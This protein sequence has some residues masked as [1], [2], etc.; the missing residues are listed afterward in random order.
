MEKAWRGGCCCCCWACGG[1]MARTP[2]LS[3]L[4]ELECWTIDVDKYWDLRNDAPLITL[5]QTKQ[6]FISPRRQ[7]NFQAFAYSVQGTCVAILHLQ[8]CHPSKYQQLQPQAWYVQAALCKGRWQVLNSP[9]PTAQDSCSFC[10]QPSTH[11]QQ[12][13]TPCMMRGGRGNARTW[14]GAQPWAWGG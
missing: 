14:A 5:H 8:S 7:N 13:R 1:S 6:A 9:L 3:E 10:Q 2:L 11:R 4:V 12:S